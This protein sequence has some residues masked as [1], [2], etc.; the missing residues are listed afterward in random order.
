MTLYV[1]HGYLSDTSGV[2]Q[3]ENKSEPCVIEELNCWI[4]LFYTEFC[5]HIKKRDHARPLCSYP[6]LHHSLC[7]TKTSLANLVGR[8]AFASVDVVTYS[9][10]WRTHLRGSAAEALILPAGLIEPAAEQADGSE[11]G[12]R[13]GGAES[14]A[15]A[16]AVDALLT[17]GAAACSVDVITQRGAKFAGIGFRDF[18]YALIFTAFLI[19]GATEKAGLGPTHDSIREKARIFGRRTSGDASAVLAR[20][21]PGAYGE[22][23]AVAGAAY[24]SVEQAVAWD[25]AFSMRL[26]GGI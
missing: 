9:F 26:L 19:G 17:V 14:I 4:I 8:T 6:S 18:I 20:E 23:P 24:L 7:N 25:R 11:A 16:D 22:P 12:L 21:V 15:S 13:L 1:M 10:W 3:R 2:K 5:W